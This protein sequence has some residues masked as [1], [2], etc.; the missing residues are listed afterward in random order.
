MQSAQSGDIASVYKGVSSWSSSGL[1][2]GVERCALA[3]AGCLR[4]TDVPPLAG[5]ICPR[6]LGGCHLSQPCH[7]K[8][9]ADSSVRVDSL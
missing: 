5:F 4:P 8:P 9:R 6:A 7:N 1:D 2:Q 3:V